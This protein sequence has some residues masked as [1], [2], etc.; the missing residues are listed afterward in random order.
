MRRGDIVIVALQGDFG[1]PRPALVIQSDLFAEHPTVT[2]LPITSDLRGTPLFRLNVEPEAGNGLRQ[3][4][5]IMVDKAQSVR[6]EKI[7]GRIG[8]LEDSRMLMVSQA[9]ALWMG[10]AQ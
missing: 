7:G 6:K 3:P 1:K 5:Q 2:I 8:R 10:L 4:C 9:L